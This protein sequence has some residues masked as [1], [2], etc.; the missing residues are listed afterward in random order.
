MK[1]FPEG[2][3]IKEI[4]YDSVKKEYKRMLEYKGK[5]YR[6]T[7]EYSFFYLRE[8][9]VRALGALNIGSRK[10]F[11]DNKSLIMDYMS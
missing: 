4:N 11:A 7:I 6:A 1:L 2:C 5:M 3:A 8:N 10:Y 9:G